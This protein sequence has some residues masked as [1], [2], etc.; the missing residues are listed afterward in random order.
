MKKKSFHLEF[1]KSLRMVF[2]W[3]EGDI[4]LLIFIMCPSFDKVIIPTM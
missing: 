3:I 4:K 2:E 1:S